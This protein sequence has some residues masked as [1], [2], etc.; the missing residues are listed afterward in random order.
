M[1]LLSLCGHFISLW[2]GTDAA[3]ITA[4]DGAPC[5]VDGSVRP[6]IHD[7]HTH[8]HTRAHAHIINTPLGAQHVVVGI[9]PI[10]GAFA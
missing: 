6:F 10:K 9:N 4:V 2:S 5:G 7:A 3:S 1:A 8:A